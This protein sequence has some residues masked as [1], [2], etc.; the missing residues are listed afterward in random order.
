MKTPANPGYCRCLCKIL[1]ITSNYR[2]L[3]L[4]LW[5][6]VS[7]CMYVR[8]YVHTNTYMCVEGKWK[9]S[10]THDQG[11]AST[12]LPLDSLCLTVT[13]VKDNNSR[14]VKSRGQ[15][16]RLGGNAFFCFLF[17]FPLLLLMILWFFC[18]FKA[19]VDSTGTR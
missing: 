6:C 1:Q 14:S 13:K 10:H 7:A 9:G 3:F 19:N 16:S 5:M 18:F 17:Y 4:A 2:A 11:C 15:G 12:R 8:A